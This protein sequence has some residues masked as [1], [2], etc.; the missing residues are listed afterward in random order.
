MR[1]RG[2]NNGSDKPV[3]WKP[4]MTT[5]EAEAYTKNTYYTGRVFYHGTNISAARNISSRG[6][7]PNIFNEF[8]TY[9][10]GFYVV[11]ERDMARQY[12][13]RKTQ[14]TGQ[15]GVVLELVLYV[16]NPKI[17]KTTRQF[18]TEQGAFIKQTGVTDE[19]VNIVFTNSLKAQG[20]D[21]VEITDLQFFIVFESRQVVI[22]STVE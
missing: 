20:F 8:S 1:S 6:I 5:A 18:W 22:R 11:G 15:L 4:S 2:E 13:A 19:E 14:E 9:G 12:A 17:Y 10:V 3:V 21:A 16:K 7:N